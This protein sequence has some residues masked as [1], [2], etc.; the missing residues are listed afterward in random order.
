MLDAIAAVQR[1]TPMFLISEKSMPRPVW[2]HEGG[3]YLSRTR[4]SHDE[5]DGLPRDPRHR[6]QRW[7]GVVYFKARA[8]CGE[9]GSP[10]VDLW[11]GCCLDYGA[12][13]VYGDA[14]LLSEVRT[15]LARAG[16]EGG[17]QP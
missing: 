2:L 13:V 11:E 15:I 8:D 6:D 1:Q 14:A 9:Q 4:L 3:V 5:V 16:F 17:G 10:V 12:F 7:D